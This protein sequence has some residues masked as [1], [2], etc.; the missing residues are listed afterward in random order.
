MLR[1]S[2]GH[3]LAFNLVDAGYVVAVPV[4]RMVPLVQVLAGRKLDDQVQVPQVRFRAEV[5]VTVVVHLLKHLHDG[6]RSVVLGNV[7]QDRLGVLGQVLAGRGHDSERKAGLA[8][9]VY[10]FRSINFFRFILRF[11]KR[12]VN[13]RLQEH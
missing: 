12:K 4:F 3:K 11:M 9:G 1:R 10:Y 5:I 2:F 13:L 7:R 8:V 6:V